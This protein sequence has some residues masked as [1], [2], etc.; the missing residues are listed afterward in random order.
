MLPLFPPSELRY[1]LPLKSFSHL[2]FTQRAFVDALVLSDFFSLDLS[3]LLI[4][5]LALSL[6]WP[7]SV[8]HYALQRRIQ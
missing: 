5:C 8:V 6:A 1:W 3:S 4:D 2:N 7:F